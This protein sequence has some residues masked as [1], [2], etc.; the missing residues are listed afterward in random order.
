MDLRSSP[1]AGASASAIAE[2]AVCRLSQVRQRLAEF[3]QDVEFLAALK[4]VYCRWQMYCLPPSH[5]YGRP[6]IW[7]VPAHEAADLRLQKP[8][9]ST[10]GRFVT[11]C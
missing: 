1:P 7:P 10:P 2:M 9:A 11:G 4:F 3:I 5:A 6:L 8:I